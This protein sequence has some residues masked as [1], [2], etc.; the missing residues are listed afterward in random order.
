MTATAAAGA[1]AP[2]TSPSTPDGAHRRLPRLGGHLPALAGYVALATCWF[3]DVVRHLPT[4]LFSDGGDGYT[5]VWNA[6]ALPRALFGGHDPFVTGEMF[7]PIGA[8]TAF[9]TNIPFPALVSWPLQQVFGIVVAVNVVQLAAV[10]A[11]GFAAYLL[12]LR[13]CGDKRV[14][15][16]TGMAFT[17]VPYRFTQSPGHHNLN[18]TEFLPL[19]LLALLLLY[20]RPTRRR[21]VLLG[22]VMGLAL[23]TDLSYT[24]YLLIAGLVIVLWHI[25]RTLSRDLLLRLGQAAVV[26]V[27]VA[28][29]L[30]IAMI[31]ELVVHDYLD[32]IPGDGGSVGYSADVISWITPAWF[33]PVWG[34]YFREVNDL[35]TG[36][37]RM[38]F[39]GWVPLAL[40]IVAVV[41]VKHRRKWLWVTLAL[42]FFVLSLGP[43]LH[44]KGQTGTRYQY[45]AIRYSVPLPYWLLQDVPVL[46]GVRVP[47]RFSVMGALAI[48]VLAALGLLRIVRWR[49]RLGSVICAG[50]LVLIGFEFLAGPVPTQPYFIPKPYD[51]IAR[52]ADPS[53]VLEIPLQWRTGFYTRGDIDRDDTVFMVY[54][55]RH[56]KPLVSGMSARYPLRDLDALQAIPAYRQLISL[57]GYPGVSEPPTFTGTDLRRLGIG[58]VVYHR[59]RSEPQAFAYLSSL[60]LPVLADDG[61]VLVWKVP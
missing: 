29:P 38:A 31:R 58:F 27:V 16:V 52:D 11:S 1:E 3:W 14:A 61:T 53:A 37:E 43:I 24:L 35:Y 28:S 45:D 5:F 36:G 49:P 54:A 19:G 44:V 57:Q 20:E 60:R 4:R 15:F 21:A 7:H 9:N 17:Y 59:D 56:G 10:I 48:D 50:A 39:V 13:E 30:L 8:R 33:H 51:A 32:P 2:A 47:G 42:L 6:W 22:V 25:R 26:A 34:D 41:T 12:M 46:S 40:A 23:L 18:H 55:I